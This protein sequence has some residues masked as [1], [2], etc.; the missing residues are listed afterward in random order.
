MGGSGAGAIRDLVARHSIRPSKSLGQNLMID[1]NM[2]RAIA[3]EAGAGPTDHVLE[4]GAGTGALT[5]ALAATGAQVLAIEFDSQMIAA[6]KEVA[7][8]L[9]NVRIVQAD[10]MALDWP[11][12]LGP[13]DWIV[14]A[15]LPYNIAVPLVL[16]LLQGAPMVRRLIVTVQLEVG[17]R[18]TAAPGADAYGAVSARVLYFADAALVRRLPP[19]VFWP[20]PKVESALVRLERRDRPAVAADPTRLFALI[21]AGFA[22][23]RKTMRSALRRMGLEADQ[24]ARVLVGCGLHPDVRAEQMG[25]EQFACLSEAMPR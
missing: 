10:A 14:C 5:V 2:A 18:L 7:G 17:Q 24:A 22:Q 13:E 20:R 16:G 1:P 19:E 9:P 6:L 15:N 11:S 21:D 8:A 23:R 4:I 25:L 12:Q 3:A